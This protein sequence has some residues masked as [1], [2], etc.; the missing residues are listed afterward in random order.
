[1]NP[2][3]KAINEAAEEKDPNSCLNYFRKLTKLRRDNLDL[4][5]GK[6]TLLD[7]DNPHVYAYT[8]ELNRKKMLVMLNFSSKTAPV[9]TKYKSVSA[10]RLLDNYTTEA[11]SNNVEATLR[12]Y[13][14]VI[15]QLP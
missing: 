5:Y 14:A 4:V 15:Y 8:R 2:N 9:N 3:Y 6:Y 12:P 7:K 11:R 1:V 10:N 13:E